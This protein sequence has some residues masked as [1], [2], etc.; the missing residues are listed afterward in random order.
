LRG[1]SISN[2]PPPGQHASI[3]REAATPS[4]AWMWNSS[5]RAAL[6]KPTLQPSPSSATE[7]TPSGPGSWMWD[8]SRRS[9]LDPPHK[10]AT[11]PR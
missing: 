1:R 3:T 9:T 4:G 7:S 11:P 6:Q 5:D 2:L 10:A 8:S